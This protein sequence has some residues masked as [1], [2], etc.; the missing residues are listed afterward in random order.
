[1]AT[2]SEIRNYAEANG[3]TRE[4]AKQYFINKAKA[5]NKGED[6]Q[7]L[8]IK[9]DS[10]DGSVEF[11]HGIVTLP[12]NPKTS[13][14]DAIG[15]MGNTWIHDN[16]ALCMTA[17]YLAHSPTLNMARSGMIGPNTQVQGKL[18]LQTIDLDNLGCYIEY[19]VDAKGVYTDGPQ[20][21]SP[22]DV[23]TKADAV[24]KKYA[25]SHDIQFHTVA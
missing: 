9:R 17:E 7:L 21:M 12:K 5:A 13:R 23:K 22:K 19:T 11:Q 24:A 8:I 18:G 25:A 6:C 14:N 20:W 10:R 4:E 1:M 2:K 15:C 3:I 16:W